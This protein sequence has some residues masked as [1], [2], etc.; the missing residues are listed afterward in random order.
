MCATC[1]QSGDLP[2]HNAASKGHLEGVKYL[3][4]VQPDTI[5]AK[6]DVSFAISILDSP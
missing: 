1:T 3:L 2:V 6:N 4:N 5:S